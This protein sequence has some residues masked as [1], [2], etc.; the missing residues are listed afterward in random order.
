M[1]IF[2][3]LFNS[4]RTV[5]VKLDDNTKLVVK[6]TT[7]GVNAELTTTSGMFIRNE[8]A[9]FSSIDELVNSLQLSDN[10]IIK[11]LSKAF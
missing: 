11:K 2:N 9:F 10:V 1:N 3:K 4:K 5:S 6:P 7:G 8:R